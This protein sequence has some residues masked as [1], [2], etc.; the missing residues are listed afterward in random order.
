MA[1][2]LQIVPNTDAQISATISSIRQLAVDAEEQYVHYAI[3]AGRE[4]I[5]LRAVCERSG[6][7]FGDYFPKN[8]E[9]K[10]DPCK[11]PFV[12]QTGNKYMAIAGNE[13]IV[14]YAHARNALPT[15][16]TILYTLGSKIPAPQLT[17]L[18][19]HKEVTPTMTRAEAAALAKESTA[20]PE[21][22][23]APSPIK[24]KGP[25]IAADDERTPEAIVR[26]VMKNESGNTDD[27]AKAAG[28]AMQIY[29]NIR[30]LVQ[31]V[32]R[33]DL[34]PRD[35]KIV[36]LALDQIN[37]TRQAGLA[38]RSAQKIALRVFGKHAGL[39]EE[40][41][42]EQFDAAFSYAMRS[43]QNLEHSDYPQMSRQATAD[44]I[45]AVKDAIRHLNA[46][47]AKLE[48]MHP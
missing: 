32:D 8:D 34:C 9:D 5:G 27:D 36:R 6:K 3:K 1:A 11:L 21:K 40:K 42:R 28:I 38:F 18:I 43:C 13:A 4:L 31:M 47:I 24:V 14:N 37:E 10:A 48:E 17:K 44:A 30:K 33:D 25:K 35:H 29:R 41:R 26:E 19:E 23:P 45:R 7:K 12:W 39:P 2:A 16:W 15:D 20:T 22:A 46:F